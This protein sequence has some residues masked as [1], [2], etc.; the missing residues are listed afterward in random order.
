MKKIGCSI[1]IMA[2]NEEKNIARVLEAIL[3][4]KLKKV[5]IS[6][7]YV[8]A[9]GCTDKTIPI[10][11]RIAKTDKRIKLLIQKRREGKSSAV[12]LFLKHTTSK[13]VVLVGA[14]TI[15]Y[16][17]VVEKLVAPFANENI[18]MTGAHPI[19]ADSKDTFFG[20]TAHLLW[21]I[22]HQVSLQSPKL[23]EMVA[24]RKI[25][26]RIPYASVVDEATVEPLIVG[27]GY[28]LLYVPDAVVIN[29]GTESLSEFLNQRRRI[30]AG[31]LALM[32]VQGYSVST[33]SK[34]RL[35]LAWVKTFRLEPRF[36]IYS[37]LVAVLE[38]VARIL[39]T[40][41]YYFRKNSHTIWKMAP[42]TK[43]LDHALL[44]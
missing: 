7:I 39:G 15:S 10:T 41:D 40:Y 30:H 13:V 24:Y 37:P 11:K 5:N 8:I 2:Y 31:H 26:E 42:S 19:P 16:D 6:K 17:N 3:S 43:R 18:G 36:I 4:Q 34:R 25:F 32:K 14:D 9:S 28:K 23:G 44:H 1:G 20:F 27:Q 21:E 29:K 35:M 22:L 33:L 38:L 12:N